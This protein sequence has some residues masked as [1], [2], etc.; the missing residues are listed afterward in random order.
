MQANINRSIVAFRSAANLR[1]G[2]LAVEVL[3]RDNHTGVSEYC[4]GIH[5]LHLLPHSAV[6]NCRNLGWPESFTILR[7]S[8]NKIKPQKK[9]SQWSVAFWGQ[10]LTTLFVTQDDNHHPQSTHCT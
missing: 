5:S 7:A 1:K 10:R 8:D 4:Y 6:V 2:V 3:I 9:L